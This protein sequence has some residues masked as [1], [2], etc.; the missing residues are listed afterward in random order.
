MPIINYNLISTYQSI[1]IK[2]IFMSYHFLTLYFTSP[3]WRQQDSVNVILKKRVSFSKE[4]YKDN[5]QMKTFFSVVHN[6]SLDHC[7]G[8]SYVLPQ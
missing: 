1:Y 5:F 7:H 6:E 3:W 4:Q 8:L 2:F